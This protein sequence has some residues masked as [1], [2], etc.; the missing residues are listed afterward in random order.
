VYL[1]PDDGHLGL[2]DRSTLLVSR[3]EPIGGF[4]PSGTFLFESV[5]RALG[6]SSLGVILTGMGQDGVEGLRAIHRAGGH[7]LAQDEESCVVF[8][9]PG[10]AVAAGVVHS[11]VPLS[12]LALR[13][14]GCVTNIEGGRG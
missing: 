13:I 8:G 1:A 2:A 12:S 6:A 14:S 11:T 7:V 4:R 5:S 3:G 10:A 9:M